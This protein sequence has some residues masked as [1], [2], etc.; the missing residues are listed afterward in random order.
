MKCETMVRKRQIF[1]L[2]GWLKRETY[3]LKPSFQYKRTVLIRLKGVAVWKLNTSIRSKSI[4]ATSR[5]WHSL[6]TTSQ[7]C[8]WL[9]RS[10]VHNGN[11]EGTSQG[12]TLPGNDSDRKRNKEGTKKG[13][14]KGARRARRDDA[15]HSR[16]EGGGIH[17]SLVIPSSLS[18]SLVSPALDVPVTVSATC[19]PLQMRQPG[20]HPW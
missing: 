20:T 15:I 4:E 6:R 8:R 11:A 9:K 18:Q 3:F 1:P 16:D 14:R 5:R 17:M 10:C 7:L 19:Y 13:G 12:G 2:P